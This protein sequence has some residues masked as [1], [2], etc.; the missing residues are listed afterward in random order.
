MDEIIS[1]AIKSLPVFAAIHQQY[2]EELEAMRAKEAQ[3]YQEASDSELS[4]IEPCKTSDVLDK[5]GSSSDS[6][7]GSALNTTS[8]SGQK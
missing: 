7:S 1:P 8:E 5:A 4:E 2:A 6:E 3:A